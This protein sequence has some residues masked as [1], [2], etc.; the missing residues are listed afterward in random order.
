MPGTLSGVVQGDD[1]KLTAV[2]TFEDAQIGTGKRITVVYT[3][4]GAHASKYMVPSAT[5][6]T[7]GE[8]TKKSLIVSNQFITKSKTYDGTNTASVSVDSLVGM[9]PGE[10]VNV[11]AIATYD[12]VAVGTGKKITVTYTISGAD[13]SKYVAPPVNSTSGTI[14]KKELIVSGITVANK[15]YDGTNEA[16]ITYGGLVG[17]VGNDEVTLLSASGVFAD[18]NAGT[19]KA[20]YIAYT[21]AGAHVGNYSFQTGFERAS[22]T[23]KMVT[24]PT[25]VLASA[26]GT[27]NLPFSTPISGLLA[28][29]IGVIKNQQLLTL[30]TDY[31]ISVNDFNVS[32]AFLPVAKLAKGDE[33]A[34]GIVRENYEI[35]G[36]GWVSVTNAIPSILPQEASL[37]TNIQWGG[38]I[39]DEII[40]SA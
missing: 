33:I 12:T 39:V 34:I 29:D 11:H 4:S 16:K 35:N 37:W 19:S 40:K 6:L 36:N 23:P 5:I 18:A 13:A 7:T 17:V 30:E 10:S 25:P 26:T 31:K 38:N 8:I 3:L 21:I 24:V 1:V 32:I 20:V 14:T 28:Q 27:I 22:I 15:E 9:V 2:A